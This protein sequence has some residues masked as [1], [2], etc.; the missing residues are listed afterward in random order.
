MDGEPASSGRVAISMICTSRRAERIEHHATIVDESGGT[1][2]GVP[3]ARADDKPKAKT[4]P[5]AA[6]LESLSA[7]N[8]PRPRTSS[9][10]RSK[11]RPKRP[12]R[13]GLRRNPSPSMTVP[14]RVLAAVPRSRRARPGESVRLSV[15]SWSPSRPAA[16]RRAKRARGAKR[17]MACSRKSYATKPEIKPLLRPLGTSNDEDAENLLRE[18]MAKNPDRKLQALA[19][20]SLADGRELIAEMVDQLNQNPDLQRNFES[21]RGKRIR[22]QTDRQQ[23]TRRKKEAVELRKTLREKYADMIAD[24]SVGKPAPEIVIQDLDGK[25]AKLSALKGKVVVLDIWATWCG[26]CR[27][28]IPHERA[29][30]ERFKDKPFALVSISADEQE[31]DAQRVLVQ[32]KDALDALVERQR[33]RRDRGLE[34]PVLSHDLRHRRQGRDPAQGRARREARR[35]RQ[36]A[37]QGRARRIRPVRAP[38]GASPR[39]RCG[40]AQAQ[41]GASVRCCQTYGS[42]GLSHVSAWDRHLQHRQGLGPCPQF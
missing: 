11:H 14:P 35:G 30:V 38:A 39:H 19:C 2:L 28:M 34:R 42:R 4:D 20:K 13:A 8:L 29:M 17:S 9:S 40:E 31:R 15:R 7:R 21:V 6:A 1:G 27:A 16:A 41:T 36:R 24:V 22:R 37:A 10:S 3:I 23:S 26:P 5:A 32:G 12:R 18:V 25:E 33:G